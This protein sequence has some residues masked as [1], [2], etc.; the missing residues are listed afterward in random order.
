MTPAGTSDAPSRLRTPPINA[1]RATPAENRVHPTAAM[2]S[3]PRP[4]G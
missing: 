1:D 4:A 3:F 2:V